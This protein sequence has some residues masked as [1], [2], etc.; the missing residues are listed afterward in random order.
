MVS[1]SE[2]E[3]RHMNDDVSI[4]NDA[5]DDDG[6]DA[7]D[8]TSKNDKKLCNGF[9]PGLDWHVRVWLVRTSSREFGPHGLGSNSASLTSS[10]MQSFCKTKLFQQLFEKISRPNSM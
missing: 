7:D 8:E 5:N 4:D 6:C 1:I 3:L 10:P 2:A 9:E